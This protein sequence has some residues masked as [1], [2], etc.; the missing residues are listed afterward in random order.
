MRSAS[1]RLT[2]E[3]SCLNLTRTVWLLHA[4]GFKRRGPFPPV[5]KLDCTAVDDLFFLIV[6]P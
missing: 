1:Q 4:M 2:A 6:D 3:K 5:G